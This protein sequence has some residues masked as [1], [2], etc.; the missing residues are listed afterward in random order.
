MK[1]L[2]SIFALL[3][4][5]SITWAQNV[6]EINGTPYPTLQDALDAAYSMTGDVTI[7]LIG[8]PTGYAIVHQKAGLNITIDGNNE[9]LY[10]QI[11]VDG[12]GRSTGTETLTIQNLYFEGNTINFYS[13]LDAFVTIPSTKESGKPYYTGKYNYAHNITIK[14]CWFTSTSSS[15]DVVGIKATSGATCYNLVVKN[16]TGNNL[17]SLAQLTATEGALIDNCTATNSESFVNIAGGSAVD[18]ISNCTFTG[19]NPS[20]GYAVRELS[21]SS[22]EITLIN[23][24]FEAKNVLQLGKKV[25]PM[26]LATSMWKVELTEERWPTLSPQ[27]AQLNS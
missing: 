17:H 19:V 13:G 4:C 25:V 21:N 9:N 27:Q 18:T 20:D 14:D 23:N 15:L 16:V 5:M 7:A 3:M 26:L 6:A 22:V 2:L 1:K 10:G 11:I 12:D 24:T 8:N